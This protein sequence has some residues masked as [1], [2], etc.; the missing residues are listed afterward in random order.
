MIIIYDLQIAYNY[1]LSET[2]KSFRNK[3]KPNFPLFCV[4]RSV[5]LLLSLQ[6]LVPRCQLHLTSQLFFSSDI[7][8][9]KFGF[10]DYQ[11]YLQFNKGASTKCET[12][13]FVEKNLINLENIRI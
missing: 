2:F 12:K 6:L 9:Q 10:Q 11:I 5:D 13:T 1:I 3:E 8:P 7:K 4:L